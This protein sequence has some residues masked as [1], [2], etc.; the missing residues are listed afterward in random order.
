V[1]QDTLVQNALEDL[2]L[3]QLNTA[4]PEGEELSETFKVRA[5]PTFAVLDAEGRTLDSWIGYGRP[6][7][8]TERLAQ[9]LEE[10]ITVTQRQAPYREGS[11]REAHS[12]YR[13]AQILDPEAARREEVELL[14][15]RSV[16]SGVG[17]GQFEIEQAGHEI[18]KI[19]SGD[20]VKPEYALEVAERLIGVRGPVGDHII[21]P[22]LKMAYPFIADI[23]DPDL[24]GRRQRVLAEYTLIV[25]QDPTRALAIKRA[26]FPDGWQSDPQ[27]LNEFAWWCFENKID[28]QEA[29]QLSQ[30][31]IELSQPG[32]EQANYL[33]TL[34]ELVN[35][36]GNPQKAL[37]LIEQALQMNPDSRYLQNQLVKFQD[38]LGEHNQQEPSS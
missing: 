6:Q 26:S 8:W 27:T 34:A 23:D 12:Y 14:I 3:A 5:V 1:K 36:Q 17:A 38:L 16:F 2:I 18:E 24:D 30:R 4:E 20:T 33:D 10:P 9:A 11:Y 35:L 32:P 37:E 15:F 22:Y 29:A 21:V 19:L 13:Q 7:G 28:I 25:E 31:S